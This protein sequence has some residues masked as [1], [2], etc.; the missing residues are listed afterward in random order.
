MEKILEIFSK[1][2]KIMEISWNFVSPKKWEPCT[3]N[4][5]VW[6]PDIY[7]YKYD[8]HI[9]MKGLDTLPSTNKYTHS[10]TITLR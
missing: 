1:P 10:L 7:D 3:V 4:W 2:G 8:P 6:P 5:V 9:D